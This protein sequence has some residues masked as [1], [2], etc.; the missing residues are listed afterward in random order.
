MPRC[1]CSGNCGWYRGSSV[2]AVV[3]V[4]GIEAAVWL[5]WSLWMVS[6]QQCGCGGNCGWYRGSSVAAVVTVDGIEAAVWLR[7]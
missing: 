3:T 4:D 1:G 2:A 5:R 6:R 7:W